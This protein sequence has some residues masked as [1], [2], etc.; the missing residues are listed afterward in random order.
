MS[1]CWSTFVPPSALSKAVLLPGVCH[2]TLNCQGGKEPS[3]RA[4]GIAPQ[5]SGCR[6]RIQKSSDTRQHSPSLGDTA[7]L[8]SPRPHRLPG[9]KI[10]PSQEKNPLHYSCRKV[11][12]SVNKLLCPTLPCFHIASCVFVM[13]QHVC[14]LGVSVLN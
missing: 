1:K 8:C 9:T 6:F 13:K 10:N 11:F 4:A 5:V 2:C 12:P 14:A 3:H 7:P